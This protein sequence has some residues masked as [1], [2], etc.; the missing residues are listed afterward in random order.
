MYGSMINMS[1]G[2]LLE[3]KKTIRDWKPVIKPVLNSKV[4]E[5]LLMG[6]SRATSEDIWN[7]LEQRVW[8]GNP[9]KRLYEVVQDILHLRANIY[10]NY[11]TVNA[12]Q[13][14]DL[15][16]SIQAVMDGD[17]DRDE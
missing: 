12:Y 7:C 10:M 3:I 2:I 15:M 9:T 14:D 13:D 5:F 11:L 8:K 6:Y 4:D 1:G 16:A 17:A